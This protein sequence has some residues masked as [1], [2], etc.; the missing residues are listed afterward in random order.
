M[1]RP[2]TVRNQCHMKVFRRDSKILL[3]LW[4]I[5]TDHPGFGKAGRL[6]YLDILLERRC[7]WQMADSSSAW[8]NWVLMKRG[9]FCRRD[10][11]RTEAVD[12]LKDCMMNREM[13]DSFGMVGSSAVKDR[14]WRNFYPG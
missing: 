5:D 13:T 10:H 14:C 9:N 4:Q 1:H 11:L 2:S 12:S 7:S 6:G 8:A 3:V